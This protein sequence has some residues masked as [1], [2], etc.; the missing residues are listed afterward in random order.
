MGTGK[1]IVKM[2]GLVLAHSRK[3]KMRQFIN[4]IFRLGSD[5][6][7]T[8]EIW[9]ICDIKTRIASQW[10]TRKEYYESKK[11]KIIER[12]VRYEN[13]DTYLPPKIKPTAEIPQATAPLLLPTE[14]QEKNPDNDDAVIDKI[15]SIN[16]AVDYQYRHYEQHF[17]QNDQN[18]TQKNK[19]RDI[20]ALKNHN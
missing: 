8:R 18:E 15:P 12:T 5:A 20:P 3:N 9:D 13:I 14:Q 6:T 10:R 19:P 17:E 7:I 1:S 11:Y 4:R 16:K 2:N